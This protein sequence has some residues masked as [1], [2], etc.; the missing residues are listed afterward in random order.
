VLDELGDVIGKPKAIEGLTIECQD[1]H[2]IARH[3]AQL[4]ET[5]LGV[6]H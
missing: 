6:R 5:L 3:P 1:D 4:G 2:A